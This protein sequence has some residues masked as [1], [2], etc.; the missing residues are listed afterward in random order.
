MFE[1]DDDS[2]WE[3]PNDDRNAINFLMTKILV[4]WATFDKKLFSKNS[5]IMRHVTPE[6]AVGD[7]PPPT[8][9]PQ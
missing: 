7:P 1:E 8:P 3:G 9:Q 2:E 6:S 4:L 5:L